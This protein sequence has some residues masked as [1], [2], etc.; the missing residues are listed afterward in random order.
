MKKMFGTR[1]DNDRQFLRGG[2]IQNSFKGNYVVLITVN[3]KDIRDGFDVVFCAGTSEGR[4]IQ[5]FHRGRHHD[6]FL[7]SE[8]L[9]GMR[10]DCSTEGKSS[11]H[12][13]RRLIERGR[14]LISACFNYREHVLD[15][16][17]PMAVPR[18]TRA[19]AL[20]H[21]AKIEFGRDE[22]QFEQSLKEGVNNLAVHCS[23]IQ[24]MR[25]RNH[26]NTAW[27][28]KIRLSQNGFQLSRRTVNK[29]L[30]VNA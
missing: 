23:A 29:N 9:R 13:W 1:N 18:V 19:L 10:L 5:S 20:F 25:V 21:T 3:D 17:Y 14:E 15:L 12:Q 8:P 26:G 27:M 11:Q 24:R 4:N 28:I 2:P 16:A 30:F 7:W 6:Q 22:S